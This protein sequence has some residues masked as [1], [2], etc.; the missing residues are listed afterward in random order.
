MED[1]IYGSIFFYLAVIH[2]HHPVSNLIDN[3]KI[4][5]DKYSGV[6]ILFINFLKQ[7]ND[8]FLNGNI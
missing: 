4:M 6:A 2:D 8:D 1:F 7:L 3:S 5:S